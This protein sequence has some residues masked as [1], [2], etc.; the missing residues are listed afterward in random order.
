MC[1]LDKQDENV[2][3][4]VFC[5]IFKPDLMYLTDVRARWFVAVYFTIRIERGYKAE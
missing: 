1:C 2:N 4:P 3:A 5:N